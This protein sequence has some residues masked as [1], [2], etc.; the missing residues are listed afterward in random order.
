[1]WVNE[2]QVV[3]YIPYYF[4]YKT[5]I[6]HIFSP[7]WKMRCILNLR[8]SYIWSNMVWCFLSTGVGDKGRNCFTW[9]WTFPTVARLRCTPGVRPP[10]HWWQCCQK[11]MLGY[12]ICLSKIQV[13][14]FIVDCYWGLSH[15]YII[16]TFC[17]SGI[18]RH[19]LRSCSMLQVLKDDFKCELSE[20]HPGI[21]A[22]HLQVIWEEWLVT[23][24]SILIA[25]QLWD[26]LV[27][28]VSMMWG[29]NHGAWFWTF[30]MSRASWI[31]I[32]IS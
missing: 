13:C 27:A 14:I 23:G 26:I 31:W 17:L 11:F 3:L 15:I 16:V 10:L 1:M 12:V 7:H 28:K 6:F 30:E 29:D 21:L 18:G 8:A 25:H 9:W 2:L 22:Y 24:R 4:K 32:H 5:H 19:H 20:E